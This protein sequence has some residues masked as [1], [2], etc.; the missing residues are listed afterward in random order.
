MFKHFPAETLAERILRHARWQFLDFGGHRVIPA[1]EEAKQ[2]NRGDNLDNL[3][4][5]EV[6]VNLVKVF[7][8]GLR[9]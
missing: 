7:L 3:A 8:C 6:P 1:I 2:S 4:F 5:V 9:G